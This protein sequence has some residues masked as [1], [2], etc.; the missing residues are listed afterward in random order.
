MHLAPPSRSLAE[1]RVAHRRKQ[2]NAVKR[3]LYPV[4]WIF[5]I[6]VLI[7]LICKIPYPT[8]GLQERIR[9]GTKIVFTL[10]HTVE[11]IHDQGTETTYYVGGVKVSSY[12]NTKTTRS[13]HTYHASTKVISAKKK[14]FTIE[15]AGKQ[16]FVAYK[17]IC[18]GHVNV[19][20]FDNSVV[21]E[22]NIT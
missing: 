1:H 16:A 8:A 5:S 6:V 14:G 19:T 20:C 17:E 3:W 7:P 9:A 10:E 13:T 11:T 21:A 18:S 22:M 15:Y 2:Q 12:R 4:V